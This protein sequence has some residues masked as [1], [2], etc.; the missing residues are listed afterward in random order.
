MART[1]DMEDEVIFLKVFKRLYPEYEQSLIDY[2]YGFK[3]Y[4]YNMFVMRKETFDAYCEFLFSI[5]F[6]CE[7]LMK[8]LPYTCSSRRWGYI[9][10][11]LL[12]IYCL[13]HHLRIR[14]EPVVSFID[15]KGDSSRN[16]KQM[17]KIQLLKKIYD[18]HKPTCIEDMCMQSVLVG[19]RNDGINL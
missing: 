18:K 1:L 11:Y 16:I 7:R 14:T 12:P 13:H 5:L 9:A 3:D 17:L 2:M 4:A 19:L 10:E 15:E 6:E 8:P